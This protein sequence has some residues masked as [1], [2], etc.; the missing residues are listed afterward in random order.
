[1]TKFNCKVNRLEHDQKTDMKITHAQ[2]KE[3]PEKIKKRIKFNSRNIKRLVTLFAFIGMNVAYA[4]LDNSASHLLPG[5]FLD[6]EKAKKIIIATNI[7]SMVENR[8]AQLQDEILSNVDSLQQLITQAK[9]T[10]NRNRVVKKILDDVFPMN[11]LP[12]S[13]HYCVAG[14]AKAK[15]MC[16]DTILNSIMPDPT[17][18]PRE[19]GFSSSPN[20]SCPFMRQFFKNTLGDNY[21][22]RGDENF[23]E[24]I[25][26]LEAGDIITVKSSR[27]SSSGEHCVTVAGP[28]QKDGSIPV[29]SLNTEDNYNV[30]PKQI[31]GAAKVIAKYREELT[32]SLVLY[33][34]N[35]YKLE[36]VI[37][38]ISGKPQNNI[39][40][41]TALRMHKLNQTRTM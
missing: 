20:I 36:P 32:N 40:M 6:D 13:T 27:N 37:P 31:V 34:E 33:Y 30:Y 10:G 3:F 7:D 14:A 15:M 38:N 35:E 9:R 18:R 29:M 2:P 16:N 1:M 22:Q 4:G 21:A 5:R 39:N 11:G 41:D 12:G 23:N 24:V 28:I 26:T 8:T 19:Y 25:N 17:K